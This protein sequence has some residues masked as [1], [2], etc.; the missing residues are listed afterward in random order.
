MLKSKTV[1]KLIET[2][3]NWNDKGE[4]F[5]VVYEVGSY[6]G[7]D[8]NCVLKQGKGT[9]TPIANYTNV[10]TPFTLEIIVP[11]QC[12]ED[13][14]DTIV[15]IVN[16]LS[17]EFHGKVQDD[18]IDNGRAIFLFNP[19]EIGS[20]ETRATAG[21]SVLIK[22][23]FI[24]E[25][26]TSVGTKYEMALINTPFDYGTQNV[27]RFNNIKEQ[28]QWIDDRIDIAP[29]YEI[30][31]PNINSLVVTQQRYLNP[32]FYDANDLL[33]KNYA[34]IKETKWNDDVNYYFYYVT[35]SNL[36][37]YNIPVFDLKMDTVQTIYFN[38]RFKFTDCQIN[39]AHISRFIKK[40]SET[41]SYDYYAF[42]FRE[43]S[44]LFE[45]EQ[46]REVSKRP[47]IRKKL[48][49]G[50]N[51]NDAGTINDW[52]EENVSHWVYYYI[53]A[54]KEYHIRNSAGALKDVASLGTIKYTTED[55]FRELAQEGNKISED[56]LQNS[57]DGS[58]VV[59]VA[60]IY[61]GDKKIYL[62]YTENQQT[63]EVGYHAWDILAIK[64][65]LKANENFAN[66]YAIKNSILPPF[67]SSG[68]YETLMRVDGGNVYYE[69]KAG[70]L[71]FPRALDNFTGY[72]D[73]AN[74]L[75]IFG[76]DNATNKDKTCFAR[77]IFQNIRHDLKFYIDGELRRNRFDKEDIEANA[78]M[79][80]DPDELFKYGLEP[81][82]LNEDYS[83]YRL[84]IGGNM[85]DL[86]ISKTSASPQFIYKELLTP[87]M[88]KAML[89]YNPNESRDASSV[90]TDINT[91]DFTGFMINIDLSMWFTNDALDSYLATNKNN[92]QIM[93][94]NQKYQTETSYLGA[95]ANTIMSAGSSLVSQNM[96]GVFQTFAGSV[97]D[98][99]KL[100][101]NQE[102]ERNIRT[103]TLDNMAQSPQ[104]LSAL[105]SNA[106]L[107]Q[108]VDD[109]GIYIELQQPLSQEKEMIVNTFKKYGYSLNKI[110]NIKNYDNIRTHYNYIEAN[111]E[112]VIHQ[113]IDEDGN[114][115][116][117]ETVIGGKISNAILDDLRQRFA[118]GV[119]FWNID[120]IDYNLPNYERWISEGSE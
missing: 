15:D 109:L 30:L 16:G 66:V 102:L 101:I 3:L 64:D 99:G 13:R 41:A 6:K 21:Q 88:T 31:T 7:A 51:D 84:Y 63:G 52:F 26:S 83:T 71:D 20:Y 1:A 87:D 85:Y 94:M 90:F 50:I 37:Q 56:Y 98:M 45:R 114:I 5:R 10:K 27:R 91:K 74:N 118:N 54:D 46:I 4:K 40:S 18:N 120:N 100:E 36:D 43:N 39:R 28:I 33:M 19:L 8:I 81:K 115:I 2:T 9:I 48:K 42:D 105:N 25:Y 59:I 96:M 61:K 95:M 103:L 80:E 24:V 106:M 107:I 62:P 22:V 34:I 67:R 32:G 60:P 65:F 55:I 111:I 89:I 104:S 29:F 77:V 82:L 58:V 119:R 57:V 14:V 97:V 47:T 113:D 75:Q 68:R 53:S 79:D 23:D 78:D 86:P 11:M 12:G 76:G 44:Y 17:K 38:P 69:P 93:D 72:Y 108:S 92:M 35:N 73:V 110:D 49:I 117:S 70:Y 112:N 116:E